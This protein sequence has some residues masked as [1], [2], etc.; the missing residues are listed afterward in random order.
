MSDIKHILTETSLQRPDC[1]S[2]CVIKTPYSCLY[3]LLIINTWLFETCRSQYTWIKSRKGRSVHFFVFHMYISLH[4]SEHVKCIYVFV[5]VCVKKRCWYSRLECVTLLLVLKTD[6]VDWT[7][8]TESL[9][10][11]QVKFSV[12][13]IKS[14]TITIIRK[15]KMCLIHFLFSTSCTW[16]IEG[17][18]ITQSSLSRWQISGL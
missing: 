15:I 16:F 9:V 17:Y 18:F 12:P 1:L 8:Q 13:R 14:E 6:I 10:V 11:I 4:G 5:T 2:R 3:R 7:V